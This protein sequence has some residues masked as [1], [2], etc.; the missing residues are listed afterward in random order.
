MVFF[1]FF[2]H[3]QFLVFLQIKTP[4]I[5]DLSL[6][7]IPSFSDEYVSI[8]LSHCRARSVC[9]HSLIPTKIHVLRFNFLP[10]FIKPLKR[11]RT[12]HWGWSPHKL[13]IK[14]RF[15]PLLCIHKIFRDKH[16]QVLQ[17]VFLE[18]WRYLQRIL[19]EEHQR[20]LEQMKR[21]I[22]E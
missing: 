13:L 17:K 18:N 22:T 19:T 21:Q 14:V 7:L 11:N 3:S 12:L 9:S 6:F 1:F 20:C 5:P 8:F 16:N 2:Y 10:G 4:F 15:F